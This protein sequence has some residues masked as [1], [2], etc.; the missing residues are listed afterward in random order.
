MT[1]GSQGGWWLHKNQ[2]WKAIQPHTCEEHIFSGDV[3]RQEKNR[4]KKWNLTG[5]TVQTAEAPLPVPA[6]VVLRRVRREGG[7]S[8]GRVWHRCRCSVS[9]MET[10]FMWRVVG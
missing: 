2:L 7:G 9:L 1:K 6:A 10:G 4:K 8:W 3:I 5:F